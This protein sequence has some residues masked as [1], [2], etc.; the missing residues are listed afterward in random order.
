MAV[1][2]GIDQQLIA[3]LSLRQQLEAARVI[4]DLA[5]PS[6]PIG[7]SGD[8]EVLIGDLEARDLD[9]SERVGGVGRAVADPIGAVAH[10]RNVL[11]QE[12]EVE[13][14]GQR[15]WLTEHRDRAAGFVGKLD[16]PPHRGRGH[17]RHCQVGAI[18]AKGVDDH[19]GLA[20]TAG[21]D[22][23]DDVARRAV[24]YLAGQLV[25]LSPAAEEV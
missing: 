21:V 11:G 17:L 16:D 8:V 3:D 19:A 5:Q 4:G 23:G 6:A 18:P 7:I 1:V 22:G 12:P 15:A 9:P 2:L 20:I 25:R 14:A 24:G 13:R 10:P